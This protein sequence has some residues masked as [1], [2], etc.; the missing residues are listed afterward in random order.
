MDLLITLE[1]LS[2]F[3]SITTG[4]V[5][6]LLFKRQQKVLKILSTFLILMLAIQFVVMYLNLNRINN[7]FLFHLYTPIEFGLLSIILSLINSRKKTKLIING[8][9]IL[10]ILFCIF[11][12]LFIE[13]LSAFNSIARGIEGVLAIVLSIYFFYALFND[14]DTKDLLKYPYFWLFSGWLIYFSGTFFLFMYANNQGIAT[15]TYPII[16]SVLN[17][18][19][20]L[21]YIY[22]LWLG[23]RKSIS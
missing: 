14:D 3:L 4:V 13:P 20:N 5:C 23:S 18:F 9:C 16:H 10:F 15:L 1:Y 2:V 12:A 17:I 22:V 8:I 19:L 21:V 7:L 11:S 6:V